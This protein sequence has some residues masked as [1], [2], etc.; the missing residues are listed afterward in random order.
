MV[1]GWFFFPQREV[2]FCTFVRPLASGWFRKGHCWSKQSV[3]TDL[4][5]WRCT[6]HFFQ[7]WHQ[8]TPPL[9]RK[10][11]FLRVNFG[12]TDLKIPPTPHPL[13]LTSFKNGPQ[14]N[15]TLGWS[16]SSND[17]IYRI[18]NKNNLPLQLLVPGILR[19][20]VISIC[21]NSPMST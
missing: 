21:H 12:S 19:V 17:L 15:R 8:S 2:L 3:L 13:N 7:S 1:E 16:C 5:M 18:P 14:A 4:L 20:L 9:P 6:A 10:P 11:F